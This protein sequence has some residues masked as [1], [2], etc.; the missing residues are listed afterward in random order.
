MARRML[1]RVPL[2]RPR[3]VAV[4]LPARAWLLT[5]PLSLLPASTSAE[6]ALIPWPREVEWREGFFPLQEVTVVSQPEQEGWVTPLRDHL[7]AIGALAL[8]ANEIARAVLVEL[9]TLLPEEGYTLTVEE[10]RV[11]LG[12]R[13]AAGALCGLQTLRQLETHDAGGAPHWPCVRIWDAPSYA[14]R[15]TMLD[16][17]RHFYSVAFIKRYLDELARLKMN[18][19]HWHLTDDQGWRVEVKKYPRLTEVG[20]WRTEADGTR[21]GGFYT[22]AEI[23]E[24]AGYALELGITVVPEIEFPG[25]CTAALAAYPH[26]GCRAAALAVPT[27]WGVF[28]DVYCVGREETWAFLQDVLDELLPLFPSDWVHIGGDEVPKDRWRV[29]PACRERMQREGMPDEDALQAWSIR[30]L[31]VYLRTMGK[32]LIGW[33]EILAGGLD[34]TAVVEVWRGDEEARRARANGNRMIRTLYFNTS[35]AVLKLEEV[36]RYDPSVDGTSDLV[37]GAEC[38]VWSEHIDERNIGYMI[39]PR[40]QVFAER[41]WTGGAPRDD[42]GRRSGPHVDRLE[43]EGWITAREDRDL[44]H[45]RLRHD[46]QRRDWLVTTARGRPDITVAYGSADA[47]GVFTDSLRVRR[48]GRL[49]LQPAW[50]GRSVQ[51]ERVYRIESH[52][53]LG[54]KQGLSRPPDPKYGLDPERGLSD[55]LLGTDDFHD[56]LWQGWQGT[57]IAVTLDFG[58]PVEVEQLN[59]RCLQAVT[60]WI[61]L[62]RS[63]EFLCS[64]DG[65]LWSSI[66]E[67]EHAVPVEPGGQLVHDFRAQLPKPTLIRCVRAVLVNQGRMPAWHLGAGGESWIFADELVVR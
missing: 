20:A 58:S 47:A 62:P 27:H 44:F 54:A 59:I 9:D 64:C 41:L 21:Y 43:R 51:Q 23:Q 65:E 13:T 18:V 4:R 57:D 30:R 8:N 17:S 49:T 25:H 48:P 10:A 28:Q 39:F 50:N 2:L 37:M 66:A 14:W 67:V 46:P 40:L 63:I 33:D 32:Q 45:A 1:R 34:S 53:G 35:P 3:A 60:S 12:A 52:L 11:V 29:C 7:L 26:L 38:P 56:G 19:F 15:G 55:G 16:A 22:Q 6:P 61:L 42:L 31:Q 5:V 24:I 36:M